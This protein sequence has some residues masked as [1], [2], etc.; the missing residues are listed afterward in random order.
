VAVLDDGLDMLDC[1]GDRDA[2]DVN[3]LGPLGAEHDSSNLL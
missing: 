1:L 2:G 3:A